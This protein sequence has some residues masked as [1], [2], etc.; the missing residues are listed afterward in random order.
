MA[1]LCLVKGGGS[2]A[3]FVLCLVSAD[4]NAR[5]RSHP[6][7]DHSP[8]MTLFYA[9]PPIERCEE[10]PDMMISNG[11]TESGEAVGCLIPGFFL[12]GVF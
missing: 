10:R 4:V 6:V 5:L 3:E 1:L 11:A 12:V 8:F 7:H 9:F 2:Y